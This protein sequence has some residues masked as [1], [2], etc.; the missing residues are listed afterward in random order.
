MRPI[1]KRLL[2]ATVVLVVVP[3]L[4]SG[5]IVCVEDLFYD[6]RP[7]RMATVHVYVLDY[8]SGAPIPWASVE[9]YERDWWSWDYIGA[10]PVGI[11]GYTVVPAGYL[12]YD[13]CG[14]PDEEDFRIITRASGYYS[15]EFVLE[16]SYYYPSE[17]LTFYLVPW[18][19]RE[20]VG[21]EKLDDVGEPTDVFRPEGKVVKGT[22]DGAEVPVDTEDLE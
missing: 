3:A 5:C 8:Y 14:G 4:F 13:G 11:T 22:P 16:L 19:G 12:Y 10:W 21:G 18:Q 1:V 7:P 9:I 17:T 20:G 15:E 6:N 2:V